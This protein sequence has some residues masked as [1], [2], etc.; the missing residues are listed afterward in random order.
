MLQVFPHWGHQVDCECSQ[1][2]VK[3]QM[4]YA[5][6][7]SGVKDAE[8]QEDICE[9]SHICHLSQLIG[10]VNGQVGDLYPIYLTREKVL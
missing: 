9:A 2:W 7:S 3:L 1:G 4:V 10:L 6:S 8:K 5:V